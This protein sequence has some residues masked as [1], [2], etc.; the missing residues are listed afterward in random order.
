MNAV[1]VPD[2]G[3]ILRTYHANAPGCKYPRICT[4]G[5]RDMIHIRLLPDSFPATVQCSYWQGL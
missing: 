1:A 5:T 3:H 4:A 2:D